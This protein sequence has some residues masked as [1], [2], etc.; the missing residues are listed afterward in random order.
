MGF[1]EAVA[2]CF[3]KYATF[4]GRARRREYWF[5]AIF[6]TIIVLPLFIWFF[7]GMFESIFRLHAMNSELHSLQHMSESQFL[8]FFANLFSVSVWLPLLLILLYSLIILLPTIA[9]SVRRMHDIGRSGAYILLSFIPYVGSI[10]WIVLTV[11]D[12]QPGDNEYGPDP[13]APPKSEH[14]PPKDGLG[15]TL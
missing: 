2:T 10:I 4:S 9:V 12:G 11:L 14:E 8:D 1:F 15:A 3:K 7:I 5:F 13:K 6:N